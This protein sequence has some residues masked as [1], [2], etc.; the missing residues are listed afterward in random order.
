MA[1]TF[2]RM[3]SR[4]V[5]SPE[6]YQYRTRAM[7]ER[8]DID[9]TSPKAR[10]LVHKKIFRELYTANKL[11]GIQE[12]HRDRYIHKTVSEDDRGVIF[13]IEWMETDTGE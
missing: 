2:K 9:H 11:M 8:K 13:E 7:R 4:I 5:L 10:E 1:A 3:V 6:D 12:L